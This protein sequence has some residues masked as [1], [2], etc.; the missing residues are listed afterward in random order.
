MVAT[1]AVL[2]LQVTA[3]VRFSVTPPAVV[4]IAM[5]WPVSFADATA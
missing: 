5:N 1:E 3:L 2:E 4:P